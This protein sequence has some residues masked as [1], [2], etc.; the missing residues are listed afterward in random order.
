M[1]IAIITGI[2]RFESIL[3]LLGVFVLFLLILAAAYFTSKWVG[4][5]NLLQGNSHNIKIM[6]T[7]RLTQNKY[8][9]IVKIGKK[10]IVIAVTKDHVE[11]LAELAEDE[12]DFK[13]LDTLGQNANLSFKDI[14][15]KVSK[16]N[17]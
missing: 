12:L 9:Q 15:T 16:K 1:Y 7:Y 5:S 14:L 17:K 3:N 10:Y 2:S 13:E 4:K 11:K 6:E 8:I